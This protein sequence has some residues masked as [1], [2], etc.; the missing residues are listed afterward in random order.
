MWKRCVYSSHQ[1]MPT[2]IYT[3]RAERARV[4]PLRRACTALLAIKQKHIHAHITGS[5]ERGRRNLWIDSNAL[6]RL[7]IVISSTSA[8][9]L[10]VF[11]ISIL[12]CLYH[13]RHLYGVRLVTF[14]CICTCNNT[15][16]RSACFC[17]CYHCC[18]LW[19]RYQWI[20]NFFLLEQW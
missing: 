11:F 14:A 15:S 16:F 17:F 2:T 8:F 19:E 10:H 13:F 9:F 7:S 18:H 4:R 12:F 3:P 6:L 5:C 20:L 1:W